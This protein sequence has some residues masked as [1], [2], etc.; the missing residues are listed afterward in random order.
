LQFGGTFCLSQAQQERNDIVAQR[1]ATPTVR[2][3]RLAAE[4]RRLRTGAELKWEEVS[5]Q[6]GINNTT[7]YRVETARS[8]PQMRTLAALLDL[9]EVGGEQRDYLTSLCRDATQR[10]WMQPYHSELPDEYAAY[11]SFEREAKGI[12]NYESLYVP[13]LLQTK[14]YMRAVV[15]GGWLTATEAEVAARVRIRIERQGVLTKEEPL[16]FWA[17]FDEAALRR[18]VGGPDVMRAQLEHLASAAKARNITFQVIPF[19]VGA[20]PG[21]PGEF[22]LMDFADPMDTDLIY[23]DS[24]A[25]ELFLESDADVSRYRTIFDN[26]V[27]VALSP[28]DS[29]S[30]VVE[31]AEEL[32]G[33]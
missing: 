21:M 15:Q 24:M 17:V 3:R 5:A 11:I 26:L 28:K 18:V 27:A 10:G 14:D 16:K 2:Q 19:G 7:L 22:V 8:R 13:G 12:R 9:Y 29:A 4:L 6:V 30:L 31:I 23:I 32:G 20:H 25:G 33:R 1:R